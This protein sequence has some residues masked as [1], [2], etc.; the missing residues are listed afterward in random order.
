MKEIYLITGAS[1][2]IGGRLMNILLEKIENKELN[3]N[4]II[5]VLVRFN[6]KINFGKFIKNNQ[7][8]RQKK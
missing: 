6:S 2:F 7:K 4:I 3:E 1:G 8:Q 5:R